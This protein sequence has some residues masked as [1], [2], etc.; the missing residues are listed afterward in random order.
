MKYNFESNLNDNNKAIVIGVKEDFE[1]DSNFEELDALFNGNFKSYIDAGVI[2]SKFKKIE[3]S[4]AVLQTNVRKVYT[5][6][7]G[8][9]EDL[10]QL[11]L[12]EAFGTV[13]QALKKDKVTDAYLYVDS[14]SSD[15]DF[16]YDVGL[17]GEISVYEP[18]NYKK[19]FKPYE[20]TLSFNKEVNEDKLKEG[21]QAGE[22]MN[23]SRNLSEMPPNVL[24]P[25][26]L[27]ELIEKEFSGKDNVTISVK[28]DKTLKEEGYG[29]LHSVG[30]GSERKPRLVTIEYKNSDKAPVALVGKGITYDSGGYSLKPRT[31]MVSMKYDMSGAAN[32]LGMMKTL[33]DQKRAVNVVAV[34]ALAENMVKGNANRP[35]DVVIAK[36]G[37]S[38]EITNTD[39]EGRLVL[40]DAVTEAITHK[41]VVIMD[42]ATLTGAVIGALGESRTGLFTNQSRQYLEDVLKSSEKVG[43]KLWHLPMDESDEAAVKDTQVADILN[44]NLRPYGGASFAAAFINQFTE[45]YPWLHFDIAGTSQ[46]AKQNA[47]GPKAASGV[48]IRTVV[49]YILDGS[50]YD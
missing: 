6:G 44:S 26:S 31:G 48:M 16:L 35:D 24:Y 28:D 14:F 25:E 38:V 4:S 47:Y 1:N 50:M 19:D 33:V 39:A 29:L 34:L 23:F 15:D 27:V 40:G 13:L 5:V 8:K 3:S 36:N 18:F 30:D 21:Q 49:D 2:Q 9:S 7:L 46:F 43:E 11:K 20:L 32:V 37:L 10:T 41:P 42:F 12:Q 17:M 22:A 45:D